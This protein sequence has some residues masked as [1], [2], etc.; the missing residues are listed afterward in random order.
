MRWKCKIRRSENSADQRKRRIHSGGS[1][2]AG[3]YRRII[4]N[5]GGYRRIVVKTKKQ[6]VLMA[7]SK[8]ELEQIIQ[9][10]EGYRF[11]FKESVAHLDKEMVAF[12]NGSGG[13]E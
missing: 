11:E 12:A 4:A 6:E 5:A 8:K 9:D 2:Q 7:I 10:G 3:G 13:G 1:V